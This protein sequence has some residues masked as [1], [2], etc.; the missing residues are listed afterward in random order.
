MTV[1]ALLACNRA[2]C[3]FTHQKAIQARIPH[4]PGLL[5]TDYRAI[6]KNEASTEVRTRVARFRVSS[7]STTPYQL[8]LI[9]SSALS[10][11][12]LVY[13]F[14]MVFIGMPASSIRRDCPDDPNTVELC[15]EDGRRAPRAL[16]KIA[17]FSLTLDRWS[18]GEQ[19]FQPNFTNSIHHPQNAVRSQGKSRAKGK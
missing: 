1:R 3:T 14:V 19:Q 5:F 10:F 12:I 9:T 7:A 17:L 8:S 16:A 15:T 2:N 11:L 4:T 13:I 6:I 18:R